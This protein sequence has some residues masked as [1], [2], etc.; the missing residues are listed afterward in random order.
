MN[1]VPFFR[2]MFAGFLTLLAL[3]PAT[4]AS[5]AEKEIFR[6]TF[7]GQTG[8]VYASS[9]DGCISS[10]VQ[11]QAVDGRV[12]AEGRPQAVSSAYIGIWQYNYCTYSWVDAWGYTELDA[13]AFQI[14]NGLNSA[15]LNTTI[16]TYD[17]WSGNM[18]SVDVNITLEGTGDTVRSKSRYQ[19]SS[20]VY[21]H[22]YRTDSAFR[23]ATASGTITTFAGTFDVGQ[24]GSGYM[25]SV[26]NG[27][28][29]MYRP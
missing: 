21:K 15:K 10:G 25:E 8:T 9:F 2:L 6:Y 26:K 4:S 18:I 29:S 17:Y 27:N 20:P 11:V 22:T 12:K 13:D 24:S 28:M 23:S 3:A 5:A 19:Y 14:N 7:Q 1:T 16:Q